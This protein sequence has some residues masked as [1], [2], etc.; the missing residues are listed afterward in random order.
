VPTGLDDDLAMALDARNELAHRYFRESE[1]EL[2]P[3]AEELTKLDRWA[4]LFERLAAALAVPL[5]THTSSNG[6]TYL[7]HQRD[8][9]LRGGRAQRIYF[10]AREPKDGL[11]DAMPHGYVVV[12]NSRTGLPIVKKG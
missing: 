2:G 8:V 5:V 4:V 7:L 11:V 12:E 6:Q 3:V 10:F 1:S 9:T